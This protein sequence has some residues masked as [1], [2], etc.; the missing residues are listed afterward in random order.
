MTANC[1]EC[2]H[3]EW[4]YDHCKRWNCKVDSREV[5]NCC[6]CARRETPIRDMMVNPTDPTVH[7]AQAAPQEPCK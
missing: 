2:E 5:H 7:S 4:Y 1:D 3:Y 6:G